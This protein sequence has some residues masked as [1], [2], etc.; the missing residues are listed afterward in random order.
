M[1]NHFKLSRTVFTSFLIIILL[2]FSIGT[3]SIATGQSYP[4]LLNLFFFELYRPQVNS[5]W[6][7][8]LFGQNLQFLFYLIIFMTSAGIYLAGRRKGSVLGKI[9]FR[10]IILT[11]TLIMFTLVTAMQTMGLLSFF[12]VWKASQAQA[13]EVEHYRLVN[14]DAYDFAMICRQALPGRHKAKFISGLDL[15]EM[16]S[17]LVHRIL[18]YFLYPI[19]IREIFPG[20]NDCLIVFQEENP[21]IAVPKDYRVIKIYNGKNLIAVKK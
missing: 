11:A 20:D 17:M 2:A 8:V 4:K 12:Y 5:F 3:L 10:Q 6:P 13:T 9:N 1:N 15:Q 21:L 16:N 18:A 7:P 19:D 14:K